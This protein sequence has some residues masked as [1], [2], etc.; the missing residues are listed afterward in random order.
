MSNTVLIYR[1]GS[2]GDTVVALPCLHLIARTFPD[3]RRILLT[4]T[5]VNAKA[6]A[7][8][9]V[10]GESKLIHGYLSYRVGTRRIIELAKLWWKIRRLKITTLVYLAAPRGDAALKRDQSFFR[11]C[12]IT[13]I[14]GLPHKDL[15]THCYDRINDRYEAEASRL[16]RCL[17]PLGDAHVTERASWDLLLTDE[18]KARANNALTP[19]LGASFFVLGI[20][21]KLSTTDWGV[22]N[23]KALMPRLHRNFP[24]HALVLVGTQADYSQSNEVAMCWPGKSL[25][26]GGALS[27]RE[28]AAVIQLSDLYLGPDSGPM[29]LAASVGTPCVSV[30]S[31]RNRPGIWFPFGNSHSVIYHK[32]ECFGCNREVCTDER[33][34]CILSISVDEVLRA[35]RRIMSSERD[36][37]TQLVAS[38]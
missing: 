25:N 8:A 32:T 28:S 21:S 33:K 3:K 30:F 26:L 12:G 10:L 38:L 9:A 11:L 14:F 1:L 37:R 2:L 35:A 31:A 29:H 16:A 15:G 22:D 20:A 17:A 5:P 23:W 18:E 7:A 19:L 27:P 34:K 24:D 13:K 4:N 6:P 36:K